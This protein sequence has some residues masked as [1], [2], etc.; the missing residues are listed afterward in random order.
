MAEKKAGRSSQ[1]RPPMAVPNSQ[2]RLN[3]W[4]IPLQ[5][6]LANKATEGRREPSVS[7]LNQHDFPVLAIHPPVSPPKLPAAQQHPFSAPN[8]H[9]AT[10][11]PHTTGVSPSLRITMDDP[12]LEARN[13]TARLKL[14]ATETSTEREAR[15]RWEMM[16]CGIEALDIFC[17]ASNPSAAGYGSPQWL[18]W[19]DVR[20]AAAQGNTDGE[21]AKRLIASIPRYILDAYTILEKEQRRLGEYPV[22]LLYH[23]PVV[24]AFHMS[25]LC[26]DLGIA[27]KAKDVILAQKGPDGQLVFCNVLQISDE[28]LTYLDAKHERIDG[29]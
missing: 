25:C 3:A 7:P 2:S 15:V 6:R 28:Y 5:T 19:S 10:P 12:N 8:R 22:S 11:A 1:N 27:D 9:L 18:E 14:W 13:V 24:G 26:F 16:V 20:A 29:I 23:H 4:A 17:W 21:E